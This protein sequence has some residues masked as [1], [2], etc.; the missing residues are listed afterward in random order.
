[1]Y[2]DGNEFLPELIIP[3]DDSWIHAPIEYLQCDYLGSSGGGNEKG[4]FIA[5]VK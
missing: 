4:S 2:Q 5:E 1:M 3:V